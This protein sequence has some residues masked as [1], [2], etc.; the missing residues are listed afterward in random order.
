MMAQS[1]ALLKMPPTPETVCSAGNEMMSIE[2]PNLGRD[3]S[4]SMDVPMAAASTSSA[5]ASCQHQCRRRGCRHHRWPELGCRREMQENYREVRPSVRLVRIPHSLLSEVPA[6]AP[7][8]DLTTLGYA[9][10]HN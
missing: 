10:W 8:G 5:G 3:V 7:P 2:V 6:V 1:S 9:R 4:T